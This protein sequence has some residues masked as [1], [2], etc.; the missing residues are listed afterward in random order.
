MDYQPPF[1]QWLK[2]R[3]KH[4]GLTQE[5]LA[6][7]VNYSVAA[8]RKVEAGKLQPAL[9]MAQDL[10]Q[11]LD[12]PPDDRA[13][14]IEFARGTQVHDRDKGSLPE[15]LTRF[16]GRE[17][18][19]AELIGRVQT[20]R[21]LTL[22]G[23]GGV[24]K[25]RLAQQVA[26]GTLASFANGVRYAELA[27]L[28]DPALLVSTVA[29]ACGMAVSA[30]LTLDQLTSFLRSR[31]LLLVLDNC[32]HLIDAVASFTVSLLRACPRLSTLATSREA[33]NV[34]GEVAW[35]VPPLQT[36]ESA[37]LFVDRA[38]E[39]RPD[40]ALDPRDAT[41]AHV[42]EW[43][44]GM[45]LAIELAAA[46]IQ[47]LSLTDLAARLDDRFAVLT[48]GRRTALPRH[49]TLRATL[50]WSYD[51][52][53]KPER[54]LVRCLS[55]FVGGWTADLAEQVCSDSP[56]LPGSPAPSLPS[57][58][59]LPLLLQLVSK[60]LVVMEEREGETRYHYLET[61]REYGWQ[62]LTECGELAMLQRRHAEAFATLAEQSYRPLHGLQQRWW[63]LR[64]ERDYANLRAA[65]TWSF[66]PQ[67]DPLVGCRI[68]SDLQVLWQSGAH[69]DDAE[70]WA[71]LARGAINEQMPPRVLGGVWLNNAM[72][73]AVNTAPASAGTL[74]AFRQ[75]LVYYTAAGDR[76]G[77]AYA[78]SHVAFN[79]LF[80]DQRDPD[81]WH[82]LEESVAQARADGDVFVEHRV[83][84]FMGQFMWSS[85]EFARAEAIFRANVQSCRETGDLANL[86]EILRDTATLYMERLRLREALPYYRE[87]AEVA[88]QI[89]NHFEELMSECMAADCVRHLGDAPRA[90][91]LGEANLAFARDKFPPI[92][93]F[94][95]IHALT[96]ALNNVGERECARTLLVDW[97]QTL[98][99]ANGQIDP[100][101]WAHSVD[102][103]ACVVSAQGNAAR[104]AR[105][106]GLGDAAFSAV[107]RR[108]FQHNEREYAPYIAKAR[109]VLGDVAFEAARA[110]GRAM[111]PERALVFA[112]E[113]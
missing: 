54:T 91:V 19:I 86:S 42:C 64:L 97:L 55:V 88:R 87:A 39:V 52:L 101:M 104:A 36:D 2:R 70:H 71:R 69:A 108:R 95:P 66:G 41:V 111:T 7:R 105:L 102:V 98:Y 112:L 20:T 81:G 35:R 63:M 14:F 80:G 22:T 26:A 90:V 58:D 61:L 94:V 24:G 25:T 99:R 33:L 13:G 16:I 6:R 100:W 109:A 1:G 47:G 103:L 28:A 31:H 5:E 37:Q 59:V 50:D 49:Q 92:H 4:L 43:L 93:H 10:A 18:Q 21:L 40:L 12:I 72:L 23:A 89:N 110:E 106:F 84:H 34:E 74:A 76:G 77:I 53:A 9:K 107:G 27:A 29:S 56:W 45:P 17:R 68:F 73:G 8:I 57:V 83:R 3:R 79:M 30:H 15:P 44:D 46:R 78:A 75:A 67:G 32:E 11:H 38:Q 60:S 62:K 48:S 113:G 65:L 96:K 85:K 82:T 51:L